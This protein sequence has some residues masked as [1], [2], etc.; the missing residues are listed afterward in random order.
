LNQPG[1]RF[2]GAVNVTIVDDATGAP[3]AK[4]DV[5]PFTQVYEVGIVIAP[6][7]TSEAGEIVIRYPVDGTEY[8]GFRV[9]KP[10]YQDGRQTWRR[11]G[12]PGAVTCRLTASPVRPIRED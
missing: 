4:A 12:I 7:L 3:I 1:A 6:Q 5:F 9:T 8:I 2:D 11:G 10:G